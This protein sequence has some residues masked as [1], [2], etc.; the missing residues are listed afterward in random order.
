M[1]SV[2]GT[3]HV[4]VRPGP[5]FR[6]VARRRAAELL[7]SRD[8]RGDA[9]AARRTRGAL[10]RRALRHGDA[11]PQRRLRAHV[12]GAVLRGDW[13]R[14]PDE[15]WPAATRSAPGLTYLAEVYWDLEGVLLDQGFTFAYDK[16]LLDALHAQRRGAACRASC[17]SPIVRPPQDLR[18]SSRITTRPGAPSCSADR[19]PAAAALAGTVPGMRFFFDGQ[20]DGRRIRSP[21]QLARWPDEP[22]DVRGA[23][24]LR[25][26]AAFASQRL[27]H[28][29]EWEALPDRDRRRR[30]L[31]RHSCVPLAIRR[32]PRDRRGQLERVTGPR[33]HSDTRRSAAR[34]RHL[35]IR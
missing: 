31:S 14:L 16:R 29:G 6:P 13:P 1:D 4:G 18:A 12:D 24:D 32:R 28:D 7:Q 8:A 5:V 10:R 35:Q 3:V 23:R 11:R 27:L 26:G 30:H 21:V 19:V 15:F 20:Q 17:W 2:Q 22:V 9:A 34:G 33:E 25:R